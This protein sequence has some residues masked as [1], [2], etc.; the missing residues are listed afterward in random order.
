[1]STPQTAMTFSMSEDVK[2]DI[3]RI[4]KKEQRSKSAVFRDMYRSY[5]FGRALDEIQAATRTTALKLSIE[6]DDDVVDYLNGVGRFASSN[7]SKV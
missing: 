7:G 3:D 2:Q 5:K 1:M 6:T 4:A